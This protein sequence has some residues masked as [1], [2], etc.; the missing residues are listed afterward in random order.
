MENTN[1]PNALCYSC[2]YRGNIPGSAHSNCN[3]PCIKSI[4]EHPIVRI[5]GL[6]HGNM[7]RVMKPLFEIL[8]IKGNKHGIENGWFNWPVNFDPIWLEN[9]DGYKPKEQSE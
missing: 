4:A 7:G 2:V 5:A 9:C 6:T 1:K 8:N 3:H